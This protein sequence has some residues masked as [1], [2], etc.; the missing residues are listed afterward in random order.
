VRRRD[1][2]LAPVE[3]GDASLL[4]VGRG[5]LPVR[6]AP[7]LGSEYGTHELGHR[8]LGRC[9]RFEGHDGAYARIPPRGEQR[10]RCAIRDAQQSDS[11]DIPAASSEIIDDGRQVARLEGTEGNVAARGA[12][13]APQ[14]HDDTTVA[15]LGQSQRPRRQQPLVLEI[16][17]H[18][19][20]RALRRRDGFALG[21]W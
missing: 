11:R 12:A 18:E 13:V 6:D 1:V 17:M 20:Q 16:A 5:E 21:G 3:S 19:Q 8:A 15:L 14:I 7:G 4:E 9:E 2:R 10:D